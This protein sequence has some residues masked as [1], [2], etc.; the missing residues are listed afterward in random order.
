[1]QLPS[2]CVPC[3]LA[4]LL[5][6]RDG[7]SAGGGMIRGTVTVTGA[8]SSADAVV[9]VQQ[10]PGTFQPPTEPADM[11]QR[12]KEF[13]PHVLPIV[14]GARVRFLN[15]DPTHH[16]V[17]SPDHESTTSAPGDRARPRPIRS[18]SA[19]YFPA[20]IRSSVSS[21]RKCKPSLLCSRTRTFAVTDQREVPK[22]A[23]VPPGSYQLA[24]WRLKGKTLPKPVTVNANA[25]VTVDFTLG[26]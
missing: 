13:V 15:S 12:K 11:D 16:N 7:L 5:I 3:S 20:P 6:A 19:R 9:F 24:V 8:T 14:A 26:K 2:L 25:T 22:I 18:T 23:N 21:T 10:T 17:F 4:V 1:M